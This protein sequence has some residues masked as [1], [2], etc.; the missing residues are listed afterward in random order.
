MDSPEEEQ[1]LEQPKNIKLNPI[2]DGPPEVIECPGKEPSEKTKESTNTLRDDKS[3]TTPKKSLD[4]ERKQK[5]AQ[6][7]CWFGDKCKNEGK[8]EFKHEWK[9]NSPSNANVMNEAQSRKEKRKM[10]KCK[11]ASRCKWGNECEFGHSKEN[12]NTKK[13]QET[14]PKNEQG[15]MQTMM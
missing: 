15:G 5:R 3:E 4:G 8:C 7:P 9:E 11:F 14:S 12:S 2:D 1:K 6:I 10:I 13:N